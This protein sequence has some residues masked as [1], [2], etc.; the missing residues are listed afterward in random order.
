MPLTLLALV[1]LVPLSAL[2]L[3]AAPTQRLPDRTSALIEQRRET[4]MVLGLVGI[5]GIALGIGIALVG[6]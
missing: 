2:A 3:A 4:L 6:L 1:L 5:V